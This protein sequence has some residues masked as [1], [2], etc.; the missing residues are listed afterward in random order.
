MG[1]LSDIACLMGAIASIDGESAFLYCSKNSGKLLSLANGI[2][3]RSQ[4]SFMG[5][6]LSKNSIPSPARTGICPVL[7]SPASVLPYRTPARFHCV[8]RGFCL[9]HARGIVLALCKMLG[10]MEVGKAKPPARN[11]RDGPDMLAMTRCCQVSTTL[12]CC[13]VRK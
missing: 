6:I 10:L 4:Y 7:S 1:I 11:R 2:Y 5:Y 12:S 3:R 13:V 9:R 8:N